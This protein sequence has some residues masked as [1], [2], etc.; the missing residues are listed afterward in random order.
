MKGHSLFEWVQMITGL[1][2]IVGL[3]LVVIELRQSHTLSHVAN[4]Q[5]TFSG[6]LATEQTQLSENFPETFNKACVAP[7]T[8]SDEEHLEMRIYR[9]LQILN[10]ER[11]RAVQQIGGFDYDWRFVSLG[12]IN[13]WLATPVGRAQYAHWRDNLDEDLTA[14]IDEKI[15]QR[16]YYDC[17]TYLEFVKNQF[18]N[19]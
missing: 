15:E 9:N 7:E 6:M 17:Q 13:M 4:V 16:D 18:A 2:V 8:M 19:T 3:V 11:I 5:N 12:T 14:L 1:A 10:I